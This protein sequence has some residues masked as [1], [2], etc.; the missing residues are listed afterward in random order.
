MLTVDAL[1][2]SLVAQIVSAYPQPAAA[3]APAAA[4]AAVPRLGAVASETDICSRIGIEVLERGG[5]AADAIVAT[6]LCVGVT[7]MYHSGIGGGGFATVRSKRGEYEFI[8]F[9]EAAPA[10]AFE[11]M[12][13]PP[14]SN[15]AFSLFGGLASGIPGELRGLEY[16]H[17]HYGSLS[18]KELVMP[19]VN[20]ARHGF[21]V[22]ED[23]MYYIGSETFMATD[24]SWAID[25]APNGTMV[26]LG[27]TMTRK[28]YADTLELIANEGPDAYYHGHVAAATIRALQSSNGT[29]TLADLADYTVKI[30][31]ISNITYR[32]Y[33]VHTG[34]APSGGAIVSSILKII[35]GYDMSRSASLNL[36]THYLDEAFRFAYGQ[37]TLLGDPDFLDI[38]AYQESMY[39]EAT[40]AQIRDLIQPDRT[41]DVAAYNP[42]GYEVLTDSGTS[43]SVASD[44]SGLTIALTSTINTRWG[45]RVMVPETGD[46]LN[47]Q[48][49]DFSIPHTINDFGYIPTEANFIRPGKRP[50][51]SIAPTIVEYPNG[52]VYISHAAAG[53]SQIITEVAQHLWR[54]L[55]QEMTTAEALAAARMHDQ[56]SPNKVAFEAANPERG[57]TGWDDQTTDFL[58][59]LGSVV[60]HLDR[61][62][63]SGQGLRIL[64]NGT[65]EAASE[66][67]QLNSGGYAV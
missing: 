60:A 20:V 8:D 63:T 12:F 65:F 11:D 22:N 67:R 49:N 35:E 37:R 13:T 5:N 26:T 55:D 19:A 1:V 62:G 57:I 16:I 29:M 53:G 66:P 32:G 6:Q 47:N 33:K 27:Q 2:L 34:S 61:A 43:A 39:S 23:L 31:P 46:I 58:S 64:P 9:R 18:W 10:A 56:L 51:S 36:S 44:R 3:P 7:G 38:A 48:M 17:K 50:L 28:R 54:V 40:A 42:A 25:F 21:R 41:L 30:R 24:P 15:C 45:S 59:S 4:A 14:C 52:E